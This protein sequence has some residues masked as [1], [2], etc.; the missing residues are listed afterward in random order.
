MTKFTRR[1]VVLGAAGTVGGLALAPLAL[2]AS[3]YVLPENAR[4]ALRESPLVYIS[5]LKTDGEESRCH[6]EV[7]YYVDGDDVCVGST[8]DTWKVK[9]VNLGLDRARVWVADYGPEWRALNRYRSA[10]SFL[11]KVSIDESRAVYEGLMRGHAQRYPGEW[12][13]WEEKFRQQYAA[14]T[15]K[16]LRYSPV[17]D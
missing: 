10:P 8:V 12:D 4:K 17:A 6:G 14:G 15:R 16:I 1:Q 5:P 7:W 11:A 9:A 2:N 3:A 13:K